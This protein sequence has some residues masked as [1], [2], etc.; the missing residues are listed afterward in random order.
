MSQAEN[1]TEFLK[2]EKSSKFK[3]FSPLLKNLKIMF[4]ILFYSFN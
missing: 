3:K 4:K 1:L 2:L